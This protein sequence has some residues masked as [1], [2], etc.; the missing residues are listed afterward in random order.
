MVCFTGLLVGL[1]NSVFW[2]FPCLCFTRCCESRSHSKQ[3]AFRR[4]PIETTSGQVPSLDTRLFLRPLG[5]PTEAFGLGQSWN[6]G[7]A[8]QCGWLS[9]ADLEMQPPRVALPW[10]TRSR[11]GLGILTTLVPP[12][13]SHLLPCKVQ[14]R[15]LCYK[16]WLSGERGSERSIGHSLGQGVI[17]IHGNFNL[18]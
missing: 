4:F 2:C 13:G 8:A 9:W 10:D 6:A 11:S 17:N 15:S 1:L 12:M 14:V 7:W 3:L 16:Q 18:V 5:Q